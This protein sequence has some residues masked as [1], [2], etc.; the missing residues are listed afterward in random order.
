MIPQPESHCEERFLS[1]TE[2]LSR[3]EGY[4]DDKDRLLS[5]TDNASKAMIYQIPRSER[6]K[7]R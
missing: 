7:D 2:G 5:S 1:S 4:Q 6:G 3:S